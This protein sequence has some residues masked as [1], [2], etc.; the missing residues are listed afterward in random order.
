MGKSYPIRPG[1]TKPGIK[2]GRI[3]II[4]KWK[5]EKNGFGYPISKEEALLEGNYTP[6]EF[7]E[8]Y[9]KMYKNWETRYSY[10]I[11]YIRIA[12]LDDNYDRI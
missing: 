10:N 4:E 8:L 2:E 12:T 9:E 11:K 1:R 7:E 5:E 6:E 3:F